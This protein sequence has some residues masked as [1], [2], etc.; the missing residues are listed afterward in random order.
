MNKEMLSTINVLYVEDESDVREFTSKT[1]EALVNKLILAS[2]GD[3]GLNVF[4]EMNDIDLVLTDVNMPKMNGLDMCKRIKEIN[5]NIPIVITSAYNDSKF[6]KKAIELGIT[7]YAMKPVDLYDLIDT[8]E[9]A[10]EPLFLRKQLQTINISLETKVQE[11]IK[12]IKSILDAQDNMVILTNGQNITNSN[13]KFLDFFAKENLESYLI[14]STCLCTKFIEEEGFFH[15]GVL[16]NNEFWIDYLQELN[17]LDKV[18]K[19]KNAYNQDR[20]FTINIDN[21]ENKNE[22][23]VISL[24]DITELKEKSNLYEYQANHDTLT[25]LYNRHKFK[26]IFSNEFKRAKRYRNDLSIIIFDIDD[27]K[28]INDNQGHLIGDEVL[29]VIGSIITSNVREHDIIVRWGGEEFI[30]LLPQTDKEGATIVAEKIRRS[31][32]D[33]ENHTFEFKMTTSCGISTLLS[34]DSEDTLLKRAD[35]GLYIAKDNGKNQIG[36][37]N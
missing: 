13:K 18:V 37:K 30:V 6:L 11:E 26:E 2:N 24:T 10:C 34:E 9:K 5:P 23:Y 22:Y 19:M 28:L 16:E 27:F 3:E 15:L 33:R 25:G 20:V 32:E 1:L 17:E 4:K 36:I 35:L 31:I 8:I 14:E 7:S 21:Y 29:K 12:K